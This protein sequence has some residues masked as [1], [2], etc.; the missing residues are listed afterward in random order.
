[1]L[2]IPT[3]THIGAP[4]VP[5]KRGDECC[6]S[7]GLPAGAGPDDVTSCKLIS[8]LSGGLCSCTHSGHLAPPPT[9]SHT[10]ELSH[11]PPHIPPVPPPIPPQTP[12]TPEPIPVPTPSFSNQ[13]SFFIAANIIRPIPIRLYTEI[14]CDWYKNLQNL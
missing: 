6:L 11:E 7:L 13:T 2:K 9:S 1:V 10:P 4:C 14:I 12:P 8:E 3:H 5:Y